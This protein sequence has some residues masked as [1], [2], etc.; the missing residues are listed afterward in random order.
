MKTCI[1][2]ILGY[3]GAD[4]GALHGKSIAAPVATRL[5]GNGLSPL[6]PAGIVVNAGRRGRTLYRGTLGELAAGTAAF[7]DGPA[8]ILLGEAVAAVTGRMPLPSP[9]ANSR[10]HRWIS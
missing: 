3:V 6:L 5:I 4:A 8:I 2:G 1:T 7:A 9:N 10:L